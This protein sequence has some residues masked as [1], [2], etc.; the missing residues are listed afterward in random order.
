MKSLSWYWQEGEGH[1]SKCPLTIDSST[2]LKDSSPKETSKFAFNDLFFLETG[3]EAVLRQKVMEETGIPKLLNYIYV[4]LYIESTS[5]IFM[6]IINMSVYR[7][8]QHFF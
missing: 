8:F 4:Y 5:F 2:M 1:R 3:D 6:F 7:V